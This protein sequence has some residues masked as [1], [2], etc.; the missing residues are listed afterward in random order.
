MDAYFAAIFIPNIL[1]MVLIAG[2]LS[3]VFIPILMQEKP[4]ENPGKASVTFSVITNF[5]LLVLVVI[6][7]C[8][9]VGAHKLLPLAFPGFN[10]PTAELAVRLIYVIFP[11]LPFLAVAGICYSLCHRF[12]QIRP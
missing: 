1:Y 5:A 6:V 11:A 7:F 3:T 4:D 2:T 10:P 9:V 12:C 8:G